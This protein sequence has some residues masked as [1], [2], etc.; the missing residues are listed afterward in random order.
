MEPTATDA[1]N[2]L[3]CRL[4]A[5]TFSGT[6]RISTP[7]GVRH[8]WCR[9]LADRG[10]GT[11]VHPGTRFATASLSKMV[12]ALTVLDGVTRG[13]LALTDRVV[14]VLRPERRPRTLSAEVTVHHLLAHTSGIADYAEEDE[15]LPGYVADYAALW[16]D[17]PCYRMRGDADLLPLFADRPAYGPPGERYR[18]SNAGYVLL[19]LIAEQAS[20]L[21]F[22]RAAADRVLGPAGMSASGYLAADEP[23]PHVATGYLAPRGVGEPW[24]SNVFSVPAVGG[25]D[26]GAY[27]TAGDADRLVRAIESGRWGDEVREQVLTRHADI[28]NG[29]SAGYGVEIGPDGAWGKDGGDPGVSALAHYDPRVGVALVVLANT[30]DTGDVVADAALRLARAVASG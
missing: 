16:Q 3:V 7:D 13:E 28:G 23:H 4:D 19:G 5:G 2:E 11:P 29:W 30:E 6:V 22:P 18:Y 9:G 8:Q 12:T 15:D 21:P 1:E 20:G 14:D 25:G 26:G 10:A 24:R 27:V 17:L